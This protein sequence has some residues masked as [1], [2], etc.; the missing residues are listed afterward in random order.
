MSTTL[1]TVNGDKAE[2]GLHPGQAR[3]WNSD[4]RFVFMIAGSQGGK[5][6]F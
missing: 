3:V 5:T 6:S 1:Y 4:R 2:L